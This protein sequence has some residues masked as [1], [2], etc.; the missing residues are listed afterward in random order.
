MP[1]AELQN[2]EPTIQL[3]PNWKYVLYNIYELAQIQSTC[4]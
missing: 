4:L 2:K 1:Q 3:E